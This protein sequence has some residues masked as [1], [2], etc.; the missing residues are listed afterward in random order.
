MVG[1]FAVWEDG[2]AGSGFLLR[3]LCVSFFGFMG[4]GVRQHWVGVCFCLHVIS[5]VFFLM[6]GGVMYDV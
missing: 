5:E 1:R 3:A 4:G 2:R 6:G